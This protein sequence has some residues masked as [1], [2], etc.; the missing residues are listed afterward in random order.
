MRVPEGVAPASGHLQNMVQHIFAGFE[1]W[2]ICI[3]DN[4]LILADSHEDAYKKLDLFLD[5]C[6]RA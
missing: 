2:T 6:L 5:R 1:E 4:F 3:F